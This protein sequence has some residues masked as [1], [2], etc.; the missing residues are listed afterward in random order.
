MGITT[1][2]MQIAREMYPQQ[3]SKIIG[4]LTFAYGVGQ[5]ISPLIAGIL[6]KD[7]GQYEAAIFFA[8]VVLVIGI[9]ALFI[10]SR[11]K[12]L[13]GFENKISEEEI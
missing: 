4:Y 9:M 5:I 1:L 6:T 10:G 8:S 12:V 11:K 7:T 3:S 2:T 13:L